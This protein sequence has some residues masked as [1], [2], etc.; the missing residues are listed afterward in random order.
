MSS[1]TSSKET[2]R[3]H[4]VGSMTLGFCLIGFGVL[5]LLHSVIAT[6]S[7][8]L[9]FSLWP[10]IF[11]CLGLELLISCISERKMVYDKAAIFLLVVMTL[12]ALGMAA[13]DVCMEA[14]RYYM[15]QE[16]YIK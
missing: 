10:V 16:I 12:F 15:E 3:V 8:D 7:Y 9:I 4:R 5:F 14:S 13:A 2:I 11:I 6:I 1:Q